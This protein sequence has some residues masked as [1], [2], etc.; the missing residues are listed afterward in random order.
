LKDPF[1]PE[2]R[3]DVMRA[4]RSKDTTPEIADRH[5]L[6]SL[7]YRYRLHRK[8]LPGKPDIVF[9]RRRMAIFVHGCFWHGHCCRRGKRIPVTNREYWERKIV[10]NKVRDTETRR[11]LAAL[12]WKTLVVWEC[13]LKDLGQ[14]ESILI[15]FLS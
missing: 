6:H 9:P 11:R 4:V 14:V 2:E 10:R 13:K 5:L 7:G 12:G 15:G 1:S 3:S 8:N